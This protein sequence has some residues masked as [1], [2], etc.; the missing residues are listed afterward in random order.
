MSLSLCYASPS[1][2]IQRSVSNIVT[3]MFPLYSFT[4]FYERELESRVFYSLLFCV[5]LED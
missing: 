5:V 1:C 4:K 2:V 3:I